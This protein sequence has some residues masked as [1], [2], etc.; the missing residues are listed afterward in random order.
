[1]SDLISRADAIEALLKEQ[2]DDIK[3]YGG[4]SIPECFDGDRAVRVLLKLP[5]FDID[6]ISRYSE[7]LW[8]LAYERG[9]A[10]GRK[11]IT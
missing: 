4:C 10:E 3:E 8:K 9:K 2:E 1:M 6:V 7:R 5:T 11:E